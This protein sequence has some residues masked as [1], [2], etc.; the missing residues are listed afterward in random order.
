[1]DTD[2][3]VIRDGVCVCVYSY[4]EHHIDLFSQWVSVDQ[5]KLQGNC[6]GVEEGAG[7]HTYRHTHT[8]YYLIFCIKALSHI[9][10]DVFSYSPLMLLYLICPQAKHMV[11]MIFPKHCYSRLGLLF[12]QGVR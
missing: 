5:G 3:L 1:M 12:I 9:L 4:L 2:Q 11:S 7:L 10:F 6:V 8:P